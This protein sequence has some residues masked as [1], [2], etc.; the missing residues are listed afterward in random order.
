MET[1]LGPI[2]MLCVFVGGCSLFFLFIVQPI[3]SV[4][5]VALSK[6][7]SGGVKATLI[8]LALLLG[9]LLT[10]F[11]ACIGSRSAFL[12]R[13]TLLS[14][15]ALLLTVGSMLG[16]AVAVPMAQQKLSWWPAFAQN[17]NSTTAPTPP[18]AGV[19]ARLPA[20]VQVAGAD[21]ATVP[22]FT[23]VHLTRNGGRWHAAIAE[24]DGHGPKSKSA[25]P[26]VLPSIYPLTHVA[27]DPKG[28]VYYGITTH[29]VARIVPD[30]GQFLEL[31]PPPG[32]RKPSWPAAIAFDSNQELLLIAARSQGYSYDPK[33]GEWQT[34]PWLSDNGLVG[35]A[36]DSGSEAL[37][38][39][40][41]EGSDAS[42]T[43][44]I[45]FN[46]KGA[47]LAKVRLSQPIPVGRYPFPLA[48]LAWAK[49]QLVCIVSPSEQDLDAGV[50]PVAR[51]YLIDPRTGDCRAVR[52]ALTKAATTPATANNNSFQ[53]LQGSWAVVKATMNGEPTHATSLLEGRWTFQ[54]DELILQ[55]PQKGK[56]RAT[57]TMDT[58]AGSKAFHVTPV[59]PATERSGWM[60]YSSEGPNLKIAFYDNFQGRPESFETRDPRAEPELVVVTL[61]PKK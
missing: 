19:Q 40:Q 9:P 36:Y 51:T 58:T 38:G 26:V 44:L 59:E 30:T 10:F 3:W 2:L 53:P 61:A 35:L 5:E 42:A 29:E 6:E 21:P 57:L 41:G 37:Y 14:F 55:S 60:L 54:G 25:T 46:A 56:V 27:V 45:Q 23:A 52:S 20:E 4:I 11:Y 22:L 39:L 31:E 49:D 24:L 48:Q 17:T 15:G 34:L 8:V 18:I 7:H 28:P 43:S 16:L 12:K 33:T 13:S 1:I 50:A 47:T 32:G